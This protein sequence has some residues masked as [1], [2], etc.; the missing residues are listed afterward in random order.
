VT[1][2]EFDS[3]LANRAKRIDG[4]IKW[5]ESKTIPNV[6]D[7]RVRVFSTSGYAL[8][9]KGSHHLLLK[10]TSFT[11]FNQKLGRI[12][13]VDFDRAHGDA[14]NCHLHRWNGNKLTVIRATASPQIASNPLTLWRWFCEQAGITHNGQLA[15]LPEQPPGQASF[16]GKSQGR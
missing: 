3:L 4:D 5:S 11:L 12:F 6:L 9:I 1:K 10:K 7:F 15:E 14:G 8:V 16:F 2:G 13:S